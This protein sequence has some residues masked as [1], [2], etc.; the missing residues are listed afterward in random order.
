MMDELARLAG[1]DPLEF[2][3]AH[4]PDGRLR[5]IL[6]DAAQRFQWSAKRG[7]DRKGRGIGL[8]CGT[9][10][11]SYTAACA[12]VELSGDKLRVVS[13]CQAYEC[14]AIQNPGNLQAQVEGCIMMGLGGALYEEIRFQDGVITNGSFS[15]YTVPRMNHLP[16]LDIVLRNRPDLPS[17]GAGETP[18]IAVAPAVANAVFDATGVRIRSMPLKTKEL[19]FV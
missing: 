1:S 16:E 14:G 12:E 11:G 3:L 15:E 18:I 9:E 6:Q 5:D 8:V 10:K 2:R 4:L 13:V 7:K 19:E 17:V